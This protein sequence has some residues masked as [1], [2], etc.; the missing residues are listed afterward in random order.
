MGHADAAGDEEHRGTQVVQNVR[1]DAAVARSEGRI[2]MIRCKERSLARDD[3]GA[4][5]APRSSVVTASRMYT[6][7]KRE[8]EIYGIS[9]H[10][11]LREK[12]F[13]SANQN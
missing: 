11:T 13:T 10:T 6:F 8:K 4:E 5:L 1:H 3:L 7:I 2:G 9:H 12:T